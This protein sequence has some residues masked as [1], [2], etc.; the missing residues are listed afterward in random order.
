MN[1]NYALEINNLY[2]NYDPSTPA[3]ENIN[4][5]IPENDYLG[6]IGPNG[7]GKSTLIKCILNLIDFQ[8]GT[9]KIF[10]SPNTVNNKVISYVPQ[11]SSMEKFFPISVREVILT[12]FNS[13]SFHPFRRY[14]KDEIK[15]T[16]SY[17]EQVQ[18]SHLADRQISGLSGGESQR[19]L[20]ARAL[21]FN[22]KILLLDEPT[23]NVDPTSRKLIFELLAKLNKK[24]TIILIT[25]DTLAVASEVKHLACLNKTLVYHGDP[26][27]NET[28]VEGLYGC[29]VDLLAHGVPHRVLGPKQN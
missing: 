26:Q 25:H 1:N 11:V 20:I 27:V 28:I 29:P 3:L 13:G 22:P 21:A 19:L 7:G 8:Q 24:M 2:V 4:L 6:I 10:G 5:K 16:E 14:S 23:S 9:I 15:K 12:S 17:L 18:I